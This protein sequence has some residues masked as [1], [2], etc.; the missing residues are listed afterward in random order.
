MPL[1]MR[2]CPVP[3]C[4]VATGGG[5]CPSH[6]RDAERARGTRQRRGYGSAHL[7]MRAVLLPLAIGTRCAICNRI[8]HE[9][10]SLDLDH[11]IPL[12][13]DRHSV[14]DRIVHASCNRS[15]TR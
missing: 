4:G 15:D 12:R 10:E 7:R 8:M 6:K 5:R 9:Y 11:S 1:A 2:L 13:I 14:G 3:G